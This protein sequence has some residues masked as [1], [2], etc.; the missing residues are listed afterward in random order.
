MADKPR[1]DLYES[2]PMHERRRS[3]VASV[4][5]NKNL[6]AKYVSLSSRLASAE[7]TIARIHNPLGDIPQEALFADVE[8]F[9]QKNGLADKTA[10]MQKGALVA[11]NPGNYENMGLE[12]DQ[13]EALRIEVSLSTSWWEYGITLQRTPT[14][15]STHSNCTSL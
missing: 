13:K 8:A 14:S 3:T 11:Q 9:C 2:G 12:E 5:L 6:D 4:N 10:L 7:L 1:A 15:G